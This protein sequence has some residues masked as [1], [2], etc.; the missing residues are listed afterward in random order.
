MH[1]CVTVSVYLY[2]YSYTP[3]FRR[4]LIPGVGGLQGF[5]ANLTS[6]SILCSRHQLTRVAVDVGAGPWGNQTIVFLGSEV[7]TV[8][9][10]LVRP[11]ASV[12]GT[13][14]PSV[15]LEEFETYRPDRSGDNQGG[16]SSRLDAR[17]AHHPH[18]PPCVPRCGRSGS[19]GEWGQRLLSLE[20]DTASGGLLAAFPRCVVRVPVARCQLH[21]GC[22]K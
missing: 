7:G 16:G 11:N 21:S 10:F 1:H 3:Q 19:G 2:N 14:G 18:S 22:M 17:V 20:L 9:K 8:L 13:T 15:F 5:G 12:S 6:N 4:C